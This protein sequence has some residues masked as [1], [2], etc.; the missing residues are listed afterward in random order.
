MC[1]P[2]RKNWIFI[3]NTN[4]VFDVRGLINKTDLVRFIDQLNYTYH[5][6]WDIEINF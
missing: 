2:T 5:L 3:N 1:C 6:E 4:T